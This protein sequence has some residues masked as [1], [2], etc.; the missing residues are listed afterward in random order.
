MTATEN[1]IERAKEI[2]T[3]SAATYEQCLA[4]IVKQDAKKG[5]KPLTK[6]DKAQMDIR[7]SNKEVTRHSDDIYAE[8]M[9]NQMSSS[10]RY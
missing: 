2:A 10:M 3:R 6:K 5:W 8:A 9:R 1:Q 4:I 7:N